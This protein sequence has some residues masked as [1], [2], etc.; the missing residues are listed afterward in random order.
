VRSL[1]EQAGME[2][3]A[4]AADGDAAVRLAG[5]LRPDV[6][7]LDLVLPGEDGAEVMRRVRRVAPGAALVVLTSYH[8]DELVARTIR[9]GALS[10]L[11]KDSE[12]DELVRAVRA[13]A[14]GESVLHPHVAARVVG[15]LRGE[16]LA[17]GLTAR[18]LEVL[19][20]VARGQTNREI[21]A[22][23]HVSEQT[24]KTHVSSVLA[25]LR[26]ADRTQ[27]AVYALRRRLVP[28]DDEGYS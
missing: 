16:R 20:R 2:V 7:L 26:L 3:A 25:K 13:A 5:E 24:V 12:P 17:E 6:V 28:L 18:E 1:L 9:A 22:G 23:L 10:Y 14:R 11:L 4:E 21:A 27:A 19:T 8:G 15:A